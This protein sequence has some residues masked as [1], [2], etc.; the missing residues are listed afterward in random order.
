MFASA[1]FCRNIFVTI[2]SLPFVCPCGRGENQHKSE[3]LVARL[4][5][6]MYS[7]A[8]AGSLGSHLSRYLSESVITSYCT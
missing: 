3:E 4:A 2:F 8:S 5:I 7:D 1:S 6:F